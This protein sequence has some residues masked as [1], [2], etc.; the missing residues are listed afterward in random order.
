MTL[1]ERRERMAAAGIPMPITQM[2]LAEGAASAVPVTPQNADLHSRLAAL[3]SGANKA[4]VHG[5]VNSKTGGASQG[6]QAIPEPKMRKN[7]NAPGVAPDKKVAVQNFAGG[8]PV[9]NEFAAMEAMMAG[10]GGGAPIAQPQY[11]MGA[12][13]QLMD[14]SQPDLAIPDDGYG[15]GPAFN[16]EGLLAK[17]RQAMQNNQYMQYA[18]NQTP[19]Q[20]Q[21]QSLP[22]MQNFNF[23]YMQQM[24]EQIARQTI[25]E[26]LNSYTEQNKSKLTYENVKVKG[27]D[28]VIKT[29]DG[30]Y[31]K[32]IPV[33]LR[34]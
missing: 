15:Y 32:L 30:K 31:Y 4:A 28:K 23:Q 33:N 18:M 29:Q 25:S 11:N 7:P 19:Q 3:K 8:A 34:K 20:P 14:N 13:Q 17:K 27:E 1:E 21:A 12:Q 2:P 26:V 22:D 9:S 6:F 10:A 24:M 5:I 16:P